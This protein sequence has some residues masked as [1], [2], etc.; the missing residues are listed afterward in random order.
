MSLSGKAL[1][2]LFILTQDFGT[3][4]I[5]INASV[6]P[7]ATKDNDLLFHRRVGWLRHRREI[8]FGQCFAQ[9]KFASQW[10]DDTAN[11]LQTPLEQKQLH[12]MIHDCSTSP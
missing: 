1:Y 2:S 8:S 6:A 12:P 10:L 11:T 9:T 4:C 7:D 3:A 5:C